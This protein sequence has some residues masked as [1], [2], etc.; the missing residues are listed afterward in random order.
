MKNQKYLNM[1]DW[2]S[3]PENYSPVKQKNTFLQQNR[4]R[5]LNLL[6]LFSDKTETTSQPLNRQNSFIQLLTTITLILL[7]SLSRDISFIWIIYMYQ[8]LQIALLPKLNMLTILKR[9]PINL[10]FVLLFILPS[11]FLTDTKTVIF[12][13]LK[14]NLILI[15]V[16]YFMN[17]NTFFDIIIVLKKCHFP[18]IIIFII[19]ITIKYLKIL[20]ESL[21]AM[22][23]AMELRSVGV[24][25]HQYQSL[26]NLFGSLYLKTKSTA[27]EMY[28]A[29]EARGFTGNYHFTRTKQRLNLSDITQ[30]CITIF[31]ITLFFN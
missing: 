31:L 25:R 1:P 19:D 2:L 8:F 6:S 15:V 20:S 11:F 9:I 12:F 16:S 17:T 10:V 24:N 18:D 7:T 23:S 14:T 30:T 28:S 21:Y 3:S 26:S 5:L 29:M 13:V 22:T 27:L 4:G